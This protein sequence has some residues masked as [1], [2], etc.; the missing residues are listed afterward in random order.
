MNE[1]FEEPRFKK[2]WLKNCQLRHFH[3]N[4]KMTV[5]SNK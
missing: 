4:I 3:T 2:V 5:I 1:Q